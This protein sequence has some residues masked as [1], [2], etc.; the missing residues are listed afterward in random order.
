MYNFQLIVP[1]GHPKTQPSYDKEMIKMVTNLKGIDRKRVRVPNSALSIQVLRFEDGAS[2]EI[3]KR[4][5][6]AFINFL[7]FEAK[8]FHQIFINVEN[9]YKKF[10]LGTPVRPSMDAWIHCIPV[11]GPELRE[12][13]IFLCQRMTAACFLNIYA[14]IIVKSN[15]YN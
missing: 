11:P 2:V 1:H 10:G 3:D 5:R 9:L 7:C 4:D 15:P 13:E 12:N 8:Y 6:P 14:R